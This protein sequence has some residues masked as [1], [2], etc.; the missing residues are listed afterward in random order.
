[1]NVFLYIL[2][3]ITYAPI[4]AY[5]YLL[6]AQITSTQ[7]QTHT[8]VVRNGRPGYY[9]G[10]IMVYGRGS[11]FVCTSGRNKIVAKPPLPT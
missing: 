9:N 2:V 5:I 8:K 3:Q 1:M 6:V 10:H 7:G 11:F 4:G